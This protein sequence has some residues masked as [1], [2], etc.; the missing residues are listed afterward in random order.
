MNF[1][2]ELTFRCVCCVLVMF[3]SRCRCFGHLKDKDEGSSAS[4]NV[5]TYFDNNVCKRLHCEN[6]VLRGNLIEEDDE[7]NEASLFF[8]VMRVIIALLVFASIVLYGERER[9]I[10]VAADIAGITLHTKTNTHTTHCYFANEYYFQ[11]PAKSRSIKM[12]L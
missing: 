12:L 4:F 5:Q 1:V 3:V 7:E 9:G 2:Y 6:G 11:N 8:N 10:F